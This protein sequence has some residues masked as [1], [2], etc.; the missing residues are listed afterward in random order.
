MLISNKSL[1]SHETKFFIEKY[2]WNFKN[3][4]KY[5]D[6]RYALL[7]VNSFLNK[8]FFK[9]PKLFEWKIIT[10]DIHK[11]NLLNALFAFQNKSDKFD[12]LKRIVK[13]IIMPN[14]LY[15][16]KDMK[17][18]YAEFHKSIEYSLLKMFLKALN[19]NINSIGYI[20]DHILYENKSSIQT[21]LWNYPTKDSKMEAHISR[22][23]GTFKEK[24]NNDFR[25]FI[26][27][28]VRKSHN[29]GILDFIDN[30]E[31]DKILFMMFFGKSHNMKLFD[32]ELKQFSKIDE[33]VLDL[34]KLLWTEKIVPDLSVLYNE[35]KQPNN[36][37]SK[38]FKLEINKFKASEASIISE[39]S[40]VFKNII[41]HDEALEKYDDD[42]M[43][44]EYKFEK[45]ENGFSVDGLKFF[46]TVLQCIHQDL[47]SVHI[48]TKMLISLFKDIPD[49]MAL[50]NS[51]FYLS[52]EKYKKIFNVMP[53][54]VKLRLL[55]KYSHS[56]DNIEKKRESFRAADPLV[57]GAAAL[58][59]VIIII[60]YKNIYFFRTDLQREKVYTMLN[61]LES[62]NKNRDYG[63]KMFNNIDKQTD[64]ILLILG[65]SK[66]HLELIQ[67]FASQIGW[68][69]QKAI[70]LFSIFKKYKDTIFRNGISNIPKF[71]K[72]LIS[73]ALR[74]AVNVEAT[75][76][77]E[78]IKKALTGGMKDVVN[79]AKENVANLSKAA[80]AQMLKVSKLVPEN[81][82]L[83]S[84]I[85]INIVYESC[86]LK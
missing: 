61:T 83:K 81:V 18:F 58:L 54:L 15:K 51:V 25:Q 36:L 19:G 4:E 67:S 63:N 21:I 77:R 26:V 37:D 11:E 40:N 68:F 78:E 56:K 62:Y 82:A 76:V 3:T 53:I 55:S 2:V 72:Q 70:D 79:I 23:I 39:N 69:D 38:G 84:K 43:K 59:N 30:Y 48:I 7:S 85:K 14:Q 47:D 66:S 65:L 5:K 8:K 73:D 17:V 71:S 46:Q 28:L 60:L 34:I 10:N 12:V 45:T 6:S 13:H 22:N 52:K 64:F 86:A 74:S 9:P 24:I 49:A 16:G 33:K 41:E 75:E 42:L 44:E 1:D 50:I 20:L 29:E 32:K 80:K 31:F 35:N 57:E 27:K